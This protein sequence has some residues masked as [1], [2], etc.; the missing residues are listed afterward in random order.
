MT[1]FKSLSKKMWNMGIIEDE[2]YIK[3]EDVKEAIKKLKEEINDGE[4]NKDIND[5]DY[6]FQEQYER[7]IYIVDKIFGKE[8]CE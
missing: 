4:N 1:E 3:S 6:I 8:L 2:M 7:L 5:T